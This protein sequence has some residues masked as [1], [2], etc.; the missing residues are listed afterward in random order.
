MAIVQVGDPAICTQIS[1]DLIKKYGHYVQVRFNLVSI[2]LK[3]FI[4]ILVN[5]D[6]KL[7][8]QKAFVWVMCT[9]ADEG[10]AQTSSYNLRQPKP[11]TV[12]SAGV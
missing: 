4:V 5:E 6:C 9:D 7:E 10:Y 11:L 1:D 8:R 12:P 3:K 2:G